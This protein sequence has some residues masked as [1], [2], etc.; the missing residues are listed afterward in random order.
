M[1]KM[2]SL[3]IS[4]VVAGLLVG[5]AFSMDNNRLMDLQQSTSRLETVKSALL[6]LE[7]E[8]MKIENMALDVENPDNHWKSAELFLALR[9]ESNKFYSEIKVLYPEIYVMLPSTPPVDLDSATKLRKALQ[10]LQRQFNNQYIA[11]LQEMKK[12]L[13]QQGQTN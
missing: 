8:A 1:S 9:E 11:Q 2:P 12:L 10:P 6:D 13:E 7:L 5:P 4:I 3:V